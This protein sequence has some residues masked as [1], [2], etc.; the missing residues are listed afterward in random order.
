MAEDN[1]GD[2]QLPSSHYL[3]ELHASL[4]GVLKHAIL[5]YGINGGIGCST[6]NDAASI[7]TTLRQYPAHLVAKSH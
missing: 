6:P 1:N 3:D 2:P 5:L 7:S 4:L